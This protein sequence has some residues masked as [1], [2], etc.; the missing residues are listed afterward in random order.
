VLAALL[1]F[2]GLGWG[3]NN[4]G[5]PSWSAYDGGQYDTINLQNLNVSLNIPVMSKSGAFPLTASL[6]SGGASIVNYNTSTGQIT[7]GIVSLPLIQSINGLISPSGYAVALP[8]SSI[9]D[10]LCPNGNG[11]TAT[12]YDNWYIQ[13]PDGTR[14]G[15]PGTDVVYGG[16]SCST[17]FTDVVGDSSGWTATINGGSYY[18]YG[19]GNATYVFTANNGMSLNLTTSQPTIIDS[20]SNTIIYEPPN[21]EVIDTMGMAALYID[22]NAANQ[23]E[24]FETNGTTTP[25]ETQTT[26]DA[27]IQT[28]YGCAGKTDYPATG[29]NYLTTSIA[30]SPDST[31]VGLGWENNEVNGAYYTGRLSSITLRGGGTINYNWNPSGSGAPYNLNCTYMVPKS[32]TRTTADG[33]RTYATSF[34]TSSPYTETVTEVTENGNKIVYKFTGFTASGN[35]GLQ[36]LTEK[37]SYTNTGTISSPSYSS[38]PDSQIIYCYNNATPTV[39]SCPTAIV[40]E[41]VREVDTYTYLG[42]ASGLLTP[43]RSQVQYDGGPSSTSPAYGNVTYS[44]LYDFGSSSLSRSVTNLYGSYNNSACIPFTTGIHNKVCQTYTSDGTNYLTSTYFEY[45]GY[46]NLA[47]TWTWNGTSSINNLSTYLTNPHNNTYNSNGT[48]SVMYDFAGNATTYKY[49]STGYSGGCPNGGN[50]PF[51]TSIT[52]GLLTTSA[53]YNCYGAVKL[54]DTDANGQ[55]TL[56]T[57][58]DTWNRIGSIQDPLGFT[59]NKYYSATSL[60]SL[61]TFGSSAI[62]NYITLDSYGRNILSQTQQSSNAFDTVSTS[63]G[64][65]NVPRTVTTGLPCTSTKEGSPCGAGD[66]VVTKFVDVLGRTVSVQDLNGYADAMSYNGKDTLSSIQPKSPGE[67][68]KQVQTESDGLGRT[69]STCAISTTVSGNVGCAQYNGSYSGVLTNVQ[70]SSTTGSQ[71]AKATR[72]AQSHTKVVDALGRVTSTTTPEAGTTTYTYDGTACG[73]STS[74]PGKLTLITFANGTTECFEYNDANG[75][76]TDSEGSSANGAYCKRFRFDSSGNSVVAAPTGYPATAYAAGRLV[77]A[78][79]DTCSGSWP[80]SVI[81]DEWFAYDK[82]GHLTDTWELTPHS[83][84]YYHATATFNGNGTVASV[85]LASPSIVTAN[86]VLDSEGRLSVLSLTPSGLGTHTIVNGVTYNAASQPKTILLGTSTD[87]DQYVYDPNSGRMTNWTFTVG[88]SSET[89]ALTWNPNGTLNELAIVD[90]FNSGGTQ[91]CVFKEANGTG[92]D[93]LG[94]L[95]GIDCGSNG[96]GQTFSY[97]QYNNLT[98]AVITGRTGTAFNPGYNTANNEYSSSF[99]ASYDLAGNLT[100]DTFNTYTWDGYNKIQSVNSSACGTNGK[101]STYDALGRL[102]ETS[103]G[104]AYLVN[105]YT[106]AGLT[107]MS[108]TTF[109]YAYWPAPGGGTAFEYGPGSGQFDYMHKDWLGSARISSVIGAQS[110]AADM[111]YSPLGEV[112]DSFQGSGIYRMFT[113]DLGQLDPEGLWD[114]SNRELPVQSRWLSPDPAGSGWNQYAY[115]TNANSGIDPSGLQ[116]QFYEPN[117]SGDNWMQATA[118]DQTFF[119]GSPFWG[120]PPYGSVG[121]DSCPC[122]LTFQQATGGWSP[123]GTGYL[124]GSDLAAPGDPLMNYLPPTTVDNALTLAYILAPLGPLVPGIASSLS[125]S[126]VMVAGLYSSV[127]A[128]TLEELADGGGPTIQVFTSLNSAPAA[129]QALSVWVGEGAEAAAGAVGGSTTYAAQ[130]PA[131]LISTMQSAGLA[132]QSTTSMNGV[133]AT[134]VMFQPNATLFIVNFFNPVIQ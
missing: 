23:L 77:E 49:M 93:D 2:A 56:Y 132:F 63:Y 106:Q 130:I 129:G 125:T 26:I 33:T 8:G 64:T 70:Y 60:S 111:A 47:K 104:S 101:C 24:W 131:A 5:T 109:K 45:D 10:L 53:T 62:N 61:F 126:T 17:S 11:T 90:G 22:P 48:P 55:N 113:G 95:T 118:F 52:K 57:Y 69:V 66:G 102:V 43:S 121:A 65:A 99:G 108:G 42:G 14:H 127:G 59:V 40:T 72:G 123:G 34:S 54:S 39:G 25:E 96:W 20:N 110:I 50:L 86:W 94:R 98:K 16:P 51:A 81:T 18:T 124:G 87:Q 35:S 105:W 12:Q 13:F 7:P 75:R 115:A 44:A 1:S 21:Q 103:N 37:Q 122:P 134:E 73:S 79:T 84:Q 6:I 4:A 85:A 83:T 29:G 107:V 100:N 71:T 116:V 133:T 82:D 19:Y 97:D 74:Y 27:T 78:E 128:A 76:M 114:T 41:P 28:S 92:Y 67:N 80:S 119:G 15:F 89:G 30:F 112:Y 88:S 117:G 36:A 120:P 91:T 3:Q 58:S 68:Y 9:P 46:G 38:T 32:M 31:S